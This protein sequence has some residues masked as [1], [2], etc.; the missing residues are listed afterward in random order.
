MKKLV[1]ILIV[2]S[3]VCLPLALA[4]QQAQA[5]TWP[6]PAAA[7]DFSFDPATGYILG[8]SGSADTVVIPDTI[9]G[10][11]VVGI[12]P[13]AFQNSTSLTRVKIGEGIKVIDYNAFYFLEKLVEVSLPAS[14][15][16]VGDFAFFQTA[17]TDVSVPAGVFYVGKNAFDIA[18]GFPSLTFTGD[19]P[20]FG[21]DALGS[22]NGS[23]VL[24]KVPA[25]RV[26]A[27]AAAL[28]RT[29]E[30]GEALVAYDRTADPADFTVSAE[31]EI[32]AYSGKAVYL[33]IPAELNGVAVSGIGEQ[34]FY[35]NA[36]LR[37]VAIPASVKSIGTSA[38]AGS[39]N[40]V[41]LILAEGLETIADD[42]FFGCPIMNLS[43][44]ASVQQIGSAAFAAC[45]TAS[46]SLPPGLSEIA[47]R[48][49]ESGDLNDVTIPAGVS[50]IGANAFG[51]N[52]E[53]T[54]LIFDGA[55]L[56]TIDATAFA[57]CPIEDIDIAW[58]ATKEAEDSAKA[59]F[60]E[61]GLA[62]DSFNVW[63]AN[64]PEA[65]GWPSADNVIEYDGTSGLVTGFTGPETNIAMFWDSWTDYNNNEKPLP[66]LGLAPHA[67]EN[68]AVER[69]YVPRSNQFTS[70]GD[71]AFAGSQLSYIDLFDSV[72]E[73]GEG[74]FENCA[75][76][77]AITL[78][79]T[80]LQIG[81]NAFAGTGLTELVLPPD[82]VVAG[83]LGLAPERIRV[84]A[85]TTDEAIET[86]RTALEYP[87]YLKLLRPGEESNYVKMPADLTA[88][89]PADF[90]FDAQTGTITAYRGQDNPLV[91]PAEIE[92]VAVRSIGNVAFNGM[93]GTDIT[94]ILPESVNEIQD[95]AF[96]M[97]EEV[98][99]IEAY[100][101]LEYVGIRAFE[102]TDKLKTVIF[103]N[104]VKTLGIYAFNETPTLQEADLG[105]MLADLP[106]GA[107]AKSG[108]TGT[109]TLNYE[110]IGQAAFNLCANVEAI[111]VPAKVKS[112]GDGAFQGM[113]ALQTM[114]FEQADA[115]VLG[116]FGYPFTA[117]MDDFEII[118]PA[119]ATDEQLAGFVKQME[120]SMLTNAAE[121]VKRGE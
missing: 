68:S 76:L 114:T 105:E 50:S 7:G 53:L 94:L 95:T 12:G 56:P 111:V 98:V 108:L 17:L 121:R 13:A 87:W 44:P 106:E 92:G 46:V 27:Y 89:A 32:S 91:V 110:T 35:A 69:F 113:S 11:A 83:P 30:A 75:N 1:L 90:D 97:W 48:L 21:E 37:G 93:S 61:L 58:D 42:A 36:M 63:R 99:R 70:I 101:P 29:V 28:G 41:S 116:D 14:L 73:I 2:L 85:E 103:H 120:Q 86:L 38:F 100:G 102:S 26:D 66:I 77:T 62:P 104:G 60:S 81:K 39:G 80:D 78:P 107:F 45:R 64:H 22:D 15:E 67:F 52:T 25:E 71:Y 10:V 88:A 5:A 8:Y 3:L 4:G 57:E 40:L 96:A 79:D 84:A 65:P 23:P 109:V 119:D 54:Y 72:N 16:Y 18:A 20:V 9:D 115:A 82:A 19:L 74:A 49:F 51:R 59:A 31:G 6:E 112:I 43:L 34:A 117:E 55:T 33:E 47:E 24:V 118:V